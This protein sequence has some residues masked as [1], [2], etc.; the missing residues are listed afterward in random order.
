MKNPCSIWWN[1]D[2][3]DPRGCLMVRLVPD[4]ILCVSEGVI[5][6]MACSPF[7][8]PVERLKKRWSS[9]PPILGWVKTLAGWKIS[10]LK[11]GRKSLKTLESPILGFLKTK[12]KVILLS[13][14]SLL[15]QPIEKIREVNFD[16]SENKAHVNFD[17][18][19]NINQP[20]FGLVKTDIRSETCVEFSYW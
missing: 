10:R 12:L 20:K 3:N 13:M 16:F 6:L 9:L 8:K 11:M 18:N 4:F 1:K 19:E 14:V 2:W 7:L 17:V 5:G 15:K